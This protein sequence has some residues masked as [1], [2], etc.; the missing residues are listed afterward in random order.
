[1]LDSTN[2]L[3]IS[4]FISEC[5]GARYFGLYHLASYPSWLFLSERLG[6]LFLHHPPVPLKSLTE[7][8]L[9]SC[10]ES[11]FL[12]AALPLLLPGW[13][14]HCFGA[15][16]NRTSCLVLSWIVAVWSQEV[17]LWS[18]KTHVHLLCSVNNNMIGLRK[19]KSEWESEDGS[20][21]PLPSVYII[22]LPLRHHS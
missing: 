17:S 16:W 11:S 7:E 15:K 10:L 5:C 2:I 12:Q 20:L 13:M 6:G 21:R 8:W 9:G 4:F 1:M 18:V 14:S 19:W 22:C 3:K